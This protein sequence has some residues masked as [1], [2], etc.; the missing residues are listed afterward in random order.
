MSALGFQPAGVGD[1]L[2]ELVLVDFAVLIYRGVADTAG[3]VVVPSDQ[4][5]AGYLWRVERMT[6]EASPLPAAGAPPAQCVVAIDASSVDSG[7]LGRLVDYSPTIP[8][9]A[10]E[11]QP[12][13]VPS[14]SYVLFAFSGLPNGAKVT[15][16]LQIAI[17]QRSRR[18]SS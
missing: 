13:T 7:S 12:I 4:V 10:D 9:V 16:R 14:S 17:Y 3:R 5:D 6:V 11:V 15:A 18:S 8:A 2:L 1:N